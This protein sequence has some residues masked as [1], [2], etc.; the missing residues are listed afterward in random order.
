MTKR[1]F[2]AAEYAAEHIGDAEPTLP[3]M[4]TV[5]EIA[6]LEGL[7][8]EC[9]QAANRHAKDPTGVWRSRVNVLEAL[10]A[11]AVRL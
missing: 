8:Y 2:Q 9:L 5:D 10:I 1:D 3:V 4:L 11:R 7:R 6:V